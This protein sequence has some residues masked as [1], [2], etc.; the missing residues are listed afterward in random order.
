MSGSEASKHLKEPNTEPEGNEID[1]WV[2]QEIRRDDLSVPTPN[3]NMKSCPKLDKLTSDKDYLRW[4]KQM[5]M[6]AT[7]MDVHEYLVESPGKIKNWSKRAAMFTTLFLHQHLGDTYLNIILELMCLHEIWVNIE[8]H[9]RR[10]VLQERIL[11]QNQLERF[12]INPHEPVEK[13][14]NR[15][16]SLV[17]NL[18][19][20]SVNYDDYSLIQRI[21]KALPQA[22][23]DFKMYK[24]YNP[25]D[26]K[27]DNFLFTVR[28]EATKLKCWDNA[29][30]KK[31]TQA[32]LY[33]NQPE[34]GKGNRDSRG[35]GNL[36]NNGRGGGRGRDGIQNVICFRCWKPGHFQRNCMEAAASPPKKY[37]HL[38]HLSFVQVPD[39]QDD[40]VE[41][42]DDD[43]SNDNQQFSLS[44]VVSL[45]KYKLMAQADEFLSCQRHST[46]FIVG[47]DSCAGEHVFRDKEL[48]TSLGRMKTPF[49]THGISGQTIVTE[50]GGTVTLYVINRDG[51]TVELEFTNAYYCP[52][53]MINLISV[54]RMSERSGGGVIFSTDSHAY[55][56]GHTRMFDIEPQYGLYVIHANRLPNNTSYC[57]MSKGKRSSG[58]LWHHRLGHVSPQVLRAMAKHDV[59]QQYDYP[60]TSTIEFCDACLEGKQA[61]RPFRRKH[62]RERPTDNH[63][64]CDLTGTF[65]VASYHKHLYGL[66]FMETSSR[67]VFGTTLAKKSEFPHTILRWIT[68][69]ERQLGKQILSTRSD[70]AGE[71]KSHAFIEALKDRG[72]LQVVN[73]GHAHQQNAQTERVI[74]TLMDM[75]RNFLFTAKLP[76]FL[77]DYAFKFAVHVYNRR[78]HSVIEKTPYERFLNRQPQLNYMRIFGAF[79]TS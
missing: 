55:P 75:T 43:K 24:R 22:F 6:A 13:E 2:D 1:P 71:M 12:S 26:E 68:L 8:K 40:A 54:P 25:L 44:S 9:C 74:C 42:D 52:D 46:C 70:A 33:A 10:N 29:I 62:T 38:Q 56:K 48:F 69:I 34:N 15:F 30:K 45:E 63:Y 66:V 67:F 17:N 79:A 53:A 78:Y 41:S 51:K 61:T 11:L 58:Q 60:I 49:E 35:G 39:T 19:G 4:S 3:L 59:E 23:S 73:V 47:V 76:L 14:I 18:R 72:V 57:F 77:W 28:A 64:S 5:L 37:E 7:F 16:R 50:Y 36:Q 32:I 21:L 65:S 31:P 27:I 20:L